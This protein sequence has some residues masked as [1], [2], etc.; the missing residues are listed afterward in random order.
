MISIVGLMTLIFSSHRRKKEHDKREPPSV[1]TD[2]L[3][4]ML[5]KFPREVAIEPA[6]SQILPVLVVKVV[7]EPNEE[8]FKTKDCLILWMHSIDDLIDAI[9][10]G[11][12]A[13]LNS[14]VSSALEAEH[15]KMSCAWSG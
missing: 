1:K 9:T 8:F 14:W 2:S 7:F 3:W 15:T 6:W 11:A 4:I 12:A 13:L 5:I 10:E